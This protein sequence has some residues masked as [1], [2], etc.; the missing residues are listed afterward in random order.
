ME[1]LLSELQEQVITLEQSSPARAFL[2][3]EEIAEL[4]PMGVVIP[5]NGAVKMII[6]F[7]IMT[8][9]VVIG[10]AI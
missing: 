2:E 5:G 1:G 4:N 6:S 7:T 8:L 9:A 10:L 3:S